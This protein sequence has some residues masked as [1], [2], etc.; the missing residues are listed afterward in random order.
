MLLLNIIKQ[1]IHI[2]YSRLDMRA[3]N[4]MD[5]RKVSVQTM[6][7]RL[8]FRGLGVTTKFI[9]TYVKKKLT[10]Y[11]FTCYIFAVDSPLRK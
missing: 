5:I 1:T 9:T 8:N 4:F 7:G 11:N 3:K 2:P 6:I 10:C